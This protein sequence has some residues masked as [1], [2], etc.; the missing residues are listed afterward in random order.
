MLQPNASPR[1]AGDEGGSAAPPAWEHQSWECLL[2]WRAIWGSCARRI[3]SWG[4][5]LRWSASDWR[6]EAKA[7][8]LASAW[9]ATR[10]FDPSRG[11]PWIVFARSRVLASVRT[12]HRQE[13]SFARF[14]SHKALPARNELPSSDSLHSDL[15]LAVL[16]SALSMLSEPDLR[17]IE[18]LFWQGGTEAA[19]SS[20]L[21]ISQPAVSKRK[22]AVLRELRRRIREAGGIEEE[23][24]L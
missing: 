18:H 20:S 24:W 16:D 14:N 1:G 15:A 21:G 13:R 19:L 6:E 10:D 22:R 11:V 5:P 8:A 7:L 12:R 9:Q 4:V 23:F 2:D 17:L 3:A